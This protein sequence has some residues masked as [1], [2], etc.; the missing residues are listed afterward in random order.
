MKWIGINV[1]ILRFGLLTVLQNETNRKGRK[2]NTH[3][4]YYLLIVLI[5]AYSILRL[6]SHPTRLIPIPPRR[7]APGA[8]IAGPV[9]SVILSKAA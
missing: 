7:I 2:H 3:G 1:P 6:L 4:P 5:T 9:V 8:G